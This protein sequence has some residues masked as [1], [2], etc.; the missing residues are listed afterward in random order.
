MNRDYRTS[1]ISIVTVTTGSRAVDFVQCLVTADREFSVIHRSSFLSSHI[2]VIITVVLIADLVFR[3][4]FLNASHCQQTRKRECQM[5]LKEYENER[6]SLRVLPNL[7]F[8]EMKHLRILQ[9]LSCE[10]YDHTEMQEH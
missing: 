3:F 4:A 7:F 1:Y 6:F 10:R 2:R 5:S 9:P 8:A